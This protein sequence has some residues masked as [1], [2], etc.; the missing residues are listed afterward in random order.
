MSR[1]RA[2]ERGEVGVLMPLNRRPSK[3]EQALLR[4]AAFASARKLVAPTGGRVLGLT[5]VALAI[6]PETGQEA[7]RMTF[8]VEAPEQAFAR[9]ADS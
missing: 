7:L 1:R 3:A 4:S 9:P 8:A 6:N 5:K 2:A